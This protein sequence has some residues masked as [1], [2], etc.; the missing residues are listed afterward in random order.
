MIVKIVKYPFQRDFSG[1]IPDEHESCMFL[2]QH[3]AFVEFLRVFAFAFVL[4]TFVEG[5]R[6]FCVVYVDAD[7]NL[8]ATIASTCRCCLEIKILRVFLASGTLRTC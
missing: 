7:D 3:Q 8:F 6:C 2:G 4:N 1:G 5:L